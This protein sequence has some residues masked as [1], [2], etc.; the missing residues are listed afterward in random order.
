MKKQKRILLSWILVI[1]T[2]IQLFFLYFVKYQNQNL[3]ISDFSILTVGNILNLIA[4]VLLISG[5]I[6]FGHVKKTIIKPAILIYFVSGTSVF[7]II[8]YLSTLFPLPFNSIYLVGQTGNKLFIGFLFSFYQITYFALI[9]F[10]WIK[11]FGGKD[12]ILTKS[13]MVS[14]SYLFLLIIFCFYF[15]TVYRINSVQPNDDNQF[16]RVGVVLGAAVW[17]KDNPST[18]FA[19]RIEKAVKLLQD[20]VITQIQFTGSNAPGELSEAE[21]AYNYAKSLMVDTTKIYIELNTT[22]TTEQIQFIKKK[23]L[24]RENIGS[25]T[26]ISDRFHLVRVEEISKFHN[27]AI[28]SASSDLELSLNSLLYNKMRES[29]ALAFFWLFAI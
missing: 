23:L 12:Y 24:T 13:F 5:I 10:V 9:Y 8:A 18:I 15:L 19:G 7:L 16:D 28:N 14:F 21:V 11:N 1:V 20:T 4:A 27:V 17:S 6:V 2:I 26:I 22:S 25:V 29:L 3:S